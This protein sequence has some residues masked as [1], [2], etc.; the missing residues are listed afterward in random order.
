MS[1]PAKR[2]SG[3]RSLVEAMKSWRTASV[4]LL[5]FSSGLPLGLVWIAIPDWMRSVGVDLRVVGLFSLTQIP[6]TF[7]FLWSPLM[8]RYAPP[9][10]GRRRGWAGLAQI[11][12][13]I[14]TFAL[15][16]VGSQPEAPWIVAALAL[17]IA[18]SSA[19]QDIA[20]DA[21]AVDV[22]REDEQGVA[23][24]ARIAV[25]RI[26]MQLAGA[27]AITLA[28]WVSWPTVNVMLACLYIPM[29][30]VTWKAPE[31]EEVHP[32]PRTLRDAV[33]L[34]FVGFLSRHRSL[35]ILAFVLTYKLSDNLATALVRPFLHDMGYDAFHRGFAMGTIGV[36]C[37]LVGTFLGGSMTTALGLGHCLWIFG[38]LQ[39][40]ASLGYVMLAG[41]GVNLPLMYSATAFESLVIGM[42]TGA[43]SVL[44]VRLTQ[45]RFSATQYALFSS[46]FGLPRLFSGPIAGFTAS[47]FG[48]RTFFWWTIA[49]GIPGLIIL[50]RFVPLGVRDPVFEVEPPRAGPRLTRAQI[51]RRGI[52]GGAFATLSG[53]LALAFLSALTKMR[54]PSG[55]GFDLVAELKALVQPVGV[56]GWTGLVGVGVFGLLFGLLSAA[57]SVAR[58]GQPESEQENDRPARPPASRAAR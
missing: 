27:W 19:T 15:A 41:T 20:I 50:S 54:D 53:A 17:A 58:Q 55:G 22:L 10:W 34:P 26:A 2:L 47:A 13:A 46:L 40:L 14:S 43:F 7:K 9:G 48:W 8:D 32:A 29:L 38:V 25:Y 28:G 12:L 30:L 37:T 45:K 33:W 11:A 52:M 49:A 5:S 1:Q 18:F 31:P 42:G 16:G 51:V 23:I 21:Y 57:V 44:L 39:A 6:W 56:A 4:V 24:G 3:Y 35:E 36:V